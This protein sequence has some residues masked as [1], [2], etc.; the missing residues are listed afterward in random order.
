MRGW[1]GDAMTYRIVCDDAPLDP[2]YPYLTDELDEI[3]AEDMRGC[4]V[5]ESRTVGGGASV[6]FTI[7]RLS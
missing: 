2:D 7:T 1:D 3:T 5:G 4:K 6:Q